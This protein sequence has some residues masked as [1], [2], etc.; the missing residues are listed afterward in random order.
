MQ[1]KVPGN[2]EKKIQETETRIARDRRGI[3]GKNSI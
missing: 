1:E 3:K 2:L